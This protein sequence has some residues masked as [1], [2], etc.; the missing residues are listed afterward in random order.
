MHAKKLMILQLRT[1][2]YGPFF[3]DFW[4]HYLRP[5]AGRKD[6]VFHFALY[7]SVCLDDL[8]SEYHTGL[9]DLKPR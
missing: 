1:R 6:G 3:F 4:P 9:K 5:S 2:V 8:N 7:K